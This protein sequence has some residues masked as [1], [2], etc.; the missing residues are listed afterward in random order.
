M[1]SMNQ[2][3]HRREDHASPYDWITLDFRLRWRS[4]R[5]QLAGDLSRATSG[6]AYSW[7]TKGIITKRL[8]GNVSSILDLGCG[9]GRNLALLPRA[10]GIDIEWPLL[11]TARTY[12]GNA[13][14][15]AA[16]DHLPFR[17]A[18]FDAVVMTEVLEHLPSPARTLAEIHRVLRL[19]G[20]LVLSTPNKRVSRFARVPGHTREYTY[21]ELKRLLFEAGF[22][23][24]E[25]TGSTIPYLPRYKRS[26]AKLDANPVV[27][28]LWRLANHSL[29]ALDSMKWDLIVL[30]RIQSR[31]SL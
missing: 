15:A 21:E 8:V 13:V 10:I 3:H 29:S 28:R 30:A 19:E 5:E 22:E 20:R 27:F 17:D 26:L 23:I 11:R 4:D 2:A 18:V 16:A 24:T 7:I 12:L 1:G 9:W 25:H 31:A 6:N 14:A